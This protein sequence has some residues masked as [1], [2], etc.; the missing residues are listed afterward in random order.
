MGVEAKVQFREDP[1]L[2]RYVEAR[3]LNPNEVAKHA[4]E[5]EVQRMRTSDSWARIRGAAIRLGR[6]TADDVRE[7]RE[8]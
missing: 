7:G 3:G 4:F 1:E 5:A 6:S 2:L 8:R